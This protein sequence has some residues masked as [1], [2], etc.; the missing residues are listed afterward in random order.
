MSIMAKQ[1]AYSMF[2]EFLRELG[3]EA[4][5][6][7]CGNE[8]ALIVFLHNN[9]PFCIIITK[10]DEQLFEMVCS[11]GAIDPTNAGQVA[12]ALD[13]CV[14]TSRESKV[15]KAYLREELLIAAVE[16]FCSPLSQVKAVFPRCLQVLADAAAGFEAKT[17]KRPAGGSTTGFMMGMAPS[18]PAP[19][20]S[21][22]KRLGLAQSSVAAGHRPGPWQQV[23]ALLKKR[24][25]K[26]RW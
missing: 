25:P 26:T 22:L 24:H 8:A 4:E 21:D 18:I 7:D 14:T 20:V 12:H 1:D 10:N 6:T 13:V 2:M 11:F 19:V 23:L 3:Y 9:R 17:P 5:G 15:V 16:M